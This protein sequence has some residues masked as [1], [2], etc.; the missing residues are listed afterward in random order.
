MNMPDYGA[1]PQETVQSD[2]LSIEELEGQNS[3]ARAAYRRSSRRSFLTFGAAA[4]AGVGGWKWLLKSGNEGGVHWP[5]RRALDASAS[6]QRSIYGDD[7][8]VATYAA[9]EAR[10]I[11][12]NGDD[13]LDPMEI[14]AATW[15]IEVQRNG[16][17]M[18]ALKLAD[19]AS[20]PQISQTVDHKCIEGWSQTVTWTGPRLRDV[21]AKADELVDGGRSSH[22]GFLTPNK[23]YYVTLERSAVQHPQ[24][25]LA[26]KLNGQPL[27]KLHGAPCRLA[28]PTR[29]GIK[30]LKRLGFINL[31][32]GFAPDYWAERGYDRY[33]A[34]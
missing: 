1:K 14:D 12:I 11:R 2:A 4:A 16:V 19:L 29:Y 13:G 32:D 25:L 17:R 26:L 30:S 18:G 8:L 27:S 5:L 23:G 20:L 10:K 21:M 31:S 34:F 7:S 24:T 22:V 15:Q 6:V 3:A 9:S 28:V 33:A